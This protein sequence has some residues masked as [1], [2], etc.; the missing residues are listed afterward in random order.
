MK[1]RLTQPSLVGIILGCIPKISFLSC[2][3]INYKLVWVGGGVE[4]EFSDRLWLELSLGQ[5]E[6]NEKEEIMHVCQAYGQWSL[7]QPI[8]CTMHM[9]LTCLPST[10]IEI[11]PPA[12]FIINASGS[13][14]IVL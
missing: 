4:S 3:E 12:C 11:L 2:L 9:F 13:A 6:Q 5:A 14:H 1:I 10:F 7:K 8:P